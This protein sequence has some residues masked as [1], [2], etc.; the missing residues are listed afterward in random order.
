MVTTGSD[1][2]T[3]L[4]IPYDTK[5]SISTVPFFVDIVQ[6]HVCIIRSI[7]VCVKLKLTIVPGIFRCEH[8]VD[9]CDTD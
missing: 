4:I 2:I 8:T 1:M 3:L 7:V 5:A 9:L 6:V